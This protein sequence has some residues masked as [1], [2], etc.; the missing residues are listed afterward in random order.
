MSAAQSQG[1]GSL[2]AHSQP[3]RSFPAHVA[4]GHLQPGVDVNDY[5]AGRRSSASSNSHEA[6]TGYSSAALASPIRRPAEYVG[7]YLGDP[8][9][10]LGYP[11]STSVSPSPSQVGLAIQNGGLSPR[12]PPRS[13]ALSQNGA[14]AV[15]GRPE[16]VND[17]IECNEA[18]DLVEPSKLSDVPSAPSPKKGPLIVDGSISS[19]P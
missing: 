14:I 18:T 9:S 8:A 4:F 16:S 15:G 11:N 12:L 6:T 10:Q 13:L 19:P 1:G 5:L 2:R 7:Y 3:A 17:T